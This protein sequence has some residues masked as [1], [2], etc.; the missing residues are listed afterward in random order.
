MPRPNRCA[1]RCCLA[2]KP[3]KPSTTLLRTMSTTV[4]GRFV[5]VKGGQLA[6]LGPRAIE[7]STEP[8]VIGRAE[9]CGIRLD[10]P[11]V[12]S[13][14]FEI[15]IT[16]RGARVRDMGSTN[17]TW[18]NGNECI[19]MYLLHPAEIRCGDQILRFTPGAPVDVDLGGYERCGELVGTSEA[20]KALYQRIRKIGATDLS[21]LI[22][23]ET[24]TGKELVAHA[25]HSV[26][27]RAGK[28]FIV[29]DCSSIPSELAESVLFGHERGAFTGAV[30]R[31]ISPF[32]EANGGTVFL[33]EIGELPALQ[34]AKLL[35]VLENGEIQPVGA[36]G[37]RPVNVRIIAATRRDL[38]KEVNGGRFRSDLFFRLRVLP[39]EVPPLREHMEDIK[40]LSEHLARVLGFGAFAH[41]FAAASYT[42][43]NKYDWPGNVRELRNTI[44]QACAFAPPDGPIDLGEYFSP[45]SRR[46][47]I[48]RKTTHFESA[49][50]ECARIFWQEQAAASPSIAELSRL[51]GVARST[52]R[53]YL[54]KY[55]LRGSD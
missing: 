17:G 44:A 5:R 29:I 20:M 39:I 50:D 6:G 1:G 14:H 28:P 30:E 55:G 47:S 36:T 31:R 21:A 12:S 51:T 26:S 2:W 4:V 48:A 32:I 40:A 35:R 22:T 53:A 34:Q 8:I 13:V 54:A 15:T 46:A 41:R 23:G 18:V 11:K 37:F 10:D 33:D 43:M 16:P 9:G 19:E 42:R 45:E 24:G 27:P 7:L 38:S 25:L 3:E 49:M 52:V